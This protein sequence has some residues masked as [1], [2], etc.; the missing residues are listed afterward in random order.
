ME[1]GHG[2]AIALKD[3]RLRDWGKGG[4]QH[5]RHSLRILTNSR[6]R[7]CAESGTEKS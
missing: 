5:K 7:S 1:K 3:F 4:N 6:I 2:A